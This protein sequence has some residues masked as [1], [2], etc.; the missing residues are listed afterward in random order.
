NKIIQGK[1]DKVQ[2]VEVTE[3]PFKLWYLPFSG[4]RITINEHFVSQPSQ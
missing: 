1:V 3:F 2:D 4:S